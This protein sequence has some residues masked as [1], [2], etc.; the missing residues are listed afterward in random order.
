[1][2]ACE[3]TLESLRQLHREMEVSSI[4]DEGLDSCQIASWF[5]MES[6]KPR[7]LEEGGERLL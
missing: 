2:A 1:M 5:I 3:G 7:L 6:S 4:L